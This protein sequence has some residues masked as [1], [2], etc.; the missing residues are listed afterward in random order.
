MGLA[1]ATDSKSYCEEL[2][3]F[4]RWRQEKISNLLSDVDAN[5]FSQQ[6]DGSFGSLFI[7]LNHLVWAEKV[8]LG[9]VNNNEVATMR[10]TAVSELLTAWKEVTDKWSHLV[11]A[12]SLEKFDDKVVYFNSKGDRFENDLAEIIVH[13]IDHSTYHIGQMMNAVRG[14]GIEPVSTN[15]IHYLRAKSQDKK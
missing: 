8:W 4:H 12:T 5:Y 1:L 9:R 2:F 14:F 7:I 10:D 13:L 6:L 3:R 11:E 15:Y